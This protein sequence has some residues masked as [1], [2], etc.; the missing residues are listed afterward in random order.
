MEYYKSRESV[1]EYI[2]LAKL[3]RSVFRD[4]TIQKQ[5][6]ITKKNKPI[7]KTIWK[8]PKKEFKKW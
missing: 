6:G 5:T 2:G 1:E 8:Q 4:T 3:E 7:W